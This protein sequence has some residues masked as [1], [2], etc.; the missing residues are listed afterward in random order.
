[1]EVHVEPNASELENQITHL[2]RSVPER[3]QLILD[4]TSLIMYLASDLA[5]AR[6]ASEPGILLNANNLHPTY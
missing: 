4:L 3:L 1:M 5:G 6:L 2:Y